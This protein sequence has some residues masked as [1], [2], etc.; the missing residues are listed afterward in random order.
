MARFEGSRAKLLSSNAWDI[1][2]VLMRRNLAARKME[3]ALSYVEINFE[4]TRLLTDDII[5]RLVNK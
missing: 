1:S 2:S 4:F 5:Q 3:S